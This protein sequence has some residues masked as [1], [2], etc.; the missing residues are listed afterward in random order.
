MEEASSAVEEV[1]PG[2]LRLMLPIPWEGG[3][4]N[5]YL[6]YGHGQA[7]LID[8]GMSVPQ[9]LAT[10]SRALEA[11]RLESVDLL[12][13]THIHPDHFGAAGEV[14]QRW[15]T[16]IF[17]HRLELPQVHERYVEID[18][19]VRDV[20]KHLR[21]HGVPEELA[22]ALSNVSRGLR[23]FVALTE[24]VALPLDGAEQFEVGGRRMRVLW[25]PGHSPGHVSV[26]L[27]DANVI[28]CGDTVLAT[29]SP[30]IGLHPQSTPDPLGDFERSLRQL[31]LYP[32]ATFLPGHGEPIREP[33]A[34]IDGL[35]EH[36]DRRR[37]RLLELL[38]P[39]GRSGW[40]LT[41]DLFGQREDEFSQRLALQEC[42]AH[43]Q[44]LAIEGS[45]VKL[46][47]QAAIVWRSS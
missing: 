9:T 1:A 45:A 12:V 47:E 34:T 6:V 20:D 16:E 24:D 27:A 32:T 21:V 36:H 38:D 4:A 11:A 18:Q 10:I 46:L 44:S 19:L 25:T 5:A 7:A 23:Q 13:V 14:R 15:G 42:L 29:S 8:C 3:H 37:Q 40:D 35:L 31:R 22:L 26:E 2:V 30:N 41:I 17:L 39:H 43:L 28:F 33:T